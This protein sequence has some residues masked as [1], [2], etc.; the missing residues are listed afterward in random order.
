MIRET[1][2]T[3]RLAA[4]IWYDF[5]LGLGGSL[6]SVRGLYTRTSSFIVVG[7]AKSTDGLIKLLD[8]LPD[9]D[10]GDRVILA[11]EMLESIRA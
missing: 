8:R 6:C 1:R 9:T 11:V 10:I 2:P 3:S 5:I 4:S 7:I